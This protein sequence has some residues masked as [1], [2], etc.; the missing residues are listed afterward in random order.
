[1][2]YWIFCILPLF[3]ILLSHSICHSQEYSLQFLASGSSNNPDID[4]VVIPLGN[5]GKPVN[6]AL[7]FTIEFWMKAKSGDNNA[8]GC[9]PNEWYFGNV[10]IDRDVFGDGDYGDYGIVLCNHRIVVGVQRSNLMHGGV[11]GNTIVDDGIW[12]H[13]AVT[14]Q[15]ST[16]GVWLYIDGILDASSNTSPSTGDISYRVGRTTT[17]PDDPTLV[18]GAEKHDYPGSLYY[19]GKL[20]EFR[21]SN[22]IRYTTNFTPQSQPFDPDAN[23][24]A[25]YHFNEGSG[26]ILTDVSGASGGPSHGTILYG[27][28]PS[29]PV[30]SYDS[31]FHPADEVTNTA[32]AGDGSLR[33]IIIDAQSGSTIVFSPLLQ[34]LTVNVNSPL[35]INKNLN[36]KDIN[37]PSISVQANNVGQVFQ[38]G[39]GASSVLMRSFMIKSGNGPNGRCI[40]NQGTLRLENMVLE[41]MSPGTGSCILN[42]GNLEIFGNVIVD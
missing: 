16:G 30:W 36:I 37:I 15:A 34:N 3:T 4:R 18:F 33:Q 9:N 13:I 32:D 5:P 2:K 10:I 41:D 39:T 21:L 28:S 26:T 14:R 42:T 20:D 38:V 8:N 1:M 29:G 6:V 31:P 23:T 7:D 12:H 22:N 19:K 27:G 40:Q 25:L 24:K 11:V 35:I 17:Y